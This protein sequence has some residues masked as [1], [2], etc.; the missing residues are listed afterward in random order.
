MTGDR[1]ELRFLLAVRLW[2]NYLTFLPLFKLHFYL[3]IIWKTGTLIPTSPALLWDNVWVTQMGGSHCDVSVTLNSPGGDGAWLKKLSCGQVPPGGGEQ[4][5]SRGKRKCSSITL[6][7]C[8]FTWKEMICLQ[9]LCNCEA[10]NNYKIF[11]LLFS[12]REGY[13]TRNRGKWWLI[14]KS[15]SYL[16]VNDWNLHL[17]THILNTCS[18]M[19]HHVRTA[20]IC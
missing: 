5:N 4:R 9:R 20:G 15:L 16:F 19:S 8:Y 6:H 3:F 12:M 11:W 10:L 18:K 17:P 7:S 1:S 14:G 13:K 2:E